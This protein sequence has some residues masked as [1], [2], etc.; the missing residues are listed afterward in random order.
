[1]C[2]QFRNT[3][4]QARTYLYK[5]NFYYNM[6]MR[7]IEILSPKFRMNLQD[8]IFP[9]R[10]DGIFRGEFGVHFYRNFSPMEKDNIILFV[11]RGNLL[12]Y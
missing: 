2:T 4:L 1:M 9:E 5:T 11:V 8:N 12:K 7:N 10:A 3:Y 6:R